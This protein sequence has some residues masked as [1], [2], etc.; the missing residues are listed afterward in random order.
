MPPKHKDKDKE[1]DPSFSNPQSS[2]TNKFPNKSKSKPKTKSSGS[3]TKEK[4]LSKKELKEL[5]KS[6]RQKS[7]VA[8]VKPRRTRRD[9]LEGLAYV[10]PG[11]LVLVLR[12]LGKYLEDLLSRSD[13]MYL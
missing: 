1:L 10:L 2:K 9:P 6:Q 13:W 11:E 8:P 12:S 5:W 7:Y 3:K 4:S